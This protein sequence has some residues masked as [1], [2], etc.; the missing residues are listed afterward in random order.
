MV[1]FEKSISAKDLTKD[2]IKFLNNDRVQGYLSKGDLFKVYRAMD[3]EIFDLLAGERGILTWFFYSIGIDVLK[4]LK[5][6]PP[7]FL[8]K[9]PVIRCDIYNG[10]KS[11]GIYAFASSSIKEVKVPGTID[12]IPTGCFQ[13][14]DNLKTAILGDGVEEI[15]SGAF[16]S[17]KSDAKIYIP[18]S[19]IAV[20]GYIFDD[21]PDIEVNCGSGSYIEDY[22]NRYKVKYKIKE[23]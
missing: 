1:E 17:I 18:D 22:C 4:E 21:S 13:E 9:T 23:K 2:C 5:T 6:V 19:V 12:Y 16:S 10:I 8:F 20:N 3:F 15:E 14:C 7:A 11:M